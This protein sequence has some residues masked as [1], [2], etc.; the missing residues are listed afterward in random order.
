MARTG[1]TEYGIYYN[2]AD[3]ITL[4]NAN[5]EWL[6]TNVVLMGGSIYSI[7]DSTE[8]DILTHSGKNNSK[9]LVTWGDIKNTS[10]DHFFYCTKFDYNDVDRSIIENDY[11]VEF[12]NPQN[13]A[14][15]FLTN[16]YDFDNKEFTGLVHNGPSL[17]KY[18]V[19]MSFGL[20]KVLGLTK[21]DILYF[22]LLKK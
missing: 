19:G 17:E 2:K 8:M 14:Q 9:D 12:F 3:D 5:G 16:D 1:I 21:D 22:R 15:S 11:K 20:M 18:G 13:L 6:K 10:K 4:I 7:D